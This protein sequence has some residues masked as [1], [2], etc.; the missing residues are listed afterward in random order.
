MLVIVLD[1]GTEC[2]FVFRVRVCV[3]VRQEE[4]H[5]CYLVSNLRFFLPLP[6]P[7]PSL[8]QPCSPSHYGH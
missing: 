5:N 4:N 6:A 2:P 8:S 3:C 7:T 1:I